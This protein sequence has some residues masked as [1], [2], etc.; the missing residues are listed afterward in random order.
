ML[1]R[2]PGA[3]L[4]QARSI[5]SVAA[6]GATEGAQTLDLSG[7]LRVRMSQRWELGVGMRR[8]DTRVETGTGSIEHGR[9]QTVTTIA[10]SF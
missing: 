10:Y 8:I 6:H 3:R 1:G 9:T 4:E 2:D 7:V 5:R